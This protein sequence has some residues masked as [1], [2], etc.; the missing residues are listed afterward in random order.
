MSALWGQG[1]NTHR[2]HAGA[3]KESRFRQF[4]SHS[5]NGAINRRAEGGPGGAGD[6]RQRTTAVAFNAEDQ[7]MYGQW[8]L[9]LLADT[10]VE[11]EV[12]DSI[13][14]ETVR[15]TLKKMG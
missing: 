8:T 2:K 12:V 15:Q 14:P 9:K 13:S 1:A 4:R 6:R 10:L 3:W 7:I 5:G 11:L